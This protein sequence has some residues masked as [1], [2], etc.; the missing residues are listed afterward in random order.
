MNSICPLDISNLPTFGGVSVDETHNSLDIPRFQMRGDDNS[1]M[2]LASA[3]STTVLFWSATL[4]LVKSNFII[5]I[6]C[7][8]S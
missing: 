4:G 6:V 1:V 2:Y 7:S 8:K 3:I 5:P